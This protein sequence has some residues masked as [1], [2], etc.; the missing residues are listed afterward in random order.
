MI[1]SVR[2][3]VLKS[4]LTLSGFSWPWVWTPGLLSGNTDGHPKYNL[5][6]MRPYPFSRN[7]CWT[8]L[9]PRH[10]NFP[11]APTI[12]RWWSP[13]FSMWNTGEHEDHPISFAEL[14]SYCIQKYKKQICSLL[15]SRNGHIISLL[16]CINT[17]K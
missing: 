1:I 4:T 8:L 5:W 14:W 12:G 16:L 10:T 17:L 2:K 6:N 3:F 13:N 11:G 7:P 15:F 9:G